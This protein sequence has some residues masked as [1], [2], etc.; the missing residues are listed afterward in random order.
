[1]KFSPT[2][3][4]ALVLAAG[5]AAA[6]AAQTAPVTASEPKAAVAKPQAGAE[7]K[8]MAGSMQ[9]QQG[10]NDNKAA[11]NAQMKSEG[12]KAKRMAHM[13]A[14]HAKR[15]AQMKARPAMAGRTAHWRHSAM[16]A[17][18]L[19]P[20]Q[21]KGAQQQLQAAGLYNG[22]TD[23]MMDP[24]TRAA[25]ARFQQQNGLR[26]TET[27]DRQTLAHLN[28]GRTSGVGSSAPGPSTTVVPSGNQGASAPP[29]AGGNAGQPIN[30]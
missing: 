1:M 23:G 27:L 20:D 13:K 14:M 12:P 4:L 16:Q 15:F 10:L 7:A 17:Q 25:L 6:A 30:K 8:P 26:R 29:S 2:V 11:S 19:T 24:D 3:P 28:S 21:V 22:P 18:K 5:M 9:G